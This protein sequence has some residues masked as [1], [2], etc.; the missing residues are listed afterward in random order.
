[1]AI[2]EKLNFTKNKTPEE[3]ALYKLVVTL[4]KAYEIEN[5]PM[6]ESPHPKNFTAFDE[7]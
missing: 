7:I 4:I 2:A 1:M 5:Y 6:E 3:A